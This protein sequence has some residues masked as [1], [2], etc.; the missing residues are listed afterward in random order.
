MNPEIK[1]I[2]S[3]VDEIVEKN[4]F[5]LID[6]ITRGNDRNKIIEVYIDGEVNVTA[7]DCASVSREIGELIDSQGLISSSYRL[8]VSSPGVDR[9]IKF[10]KQYNK[11]LNRKFEISYSK[12]EDTKKMTGKLIR[13]DG[14]DLVFYVSKNEELVVNFNSIKKSKV[15]ISFS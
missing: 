3:I 2:Y 10:L 11:H 4:G 6:F 7:E 13:I 15:V 5:F 14:E 12:G 1:K 8:D 9:P